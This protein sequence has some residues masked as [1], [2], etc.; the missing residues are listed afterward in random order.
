MEKILVKSL[1]SLILSLFIVHTYLLPLNHR[2]RMSVRDKSKNATGGQNDTFY[3]WPSL[4]TWGGGGHGVQGQIF[5]I[6]TPASY[7]S[8]PAS[9]GHTDSHTLDTYIWLVAGGG[10]ALILDRCRAFDLFASIDAYPWKMSSYIHIV[11]LK[12]VILFCFVYAGKRTP[13]FPCGSGSLQKILRCRDFCRS[14]GLFQN[15]LVSFLQY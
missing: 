5:D 6:L 9:S 11:I 13:S 7:E 4:S 1:H 14:S 10:G 3:L 8:L 12:I 15:R 2:I